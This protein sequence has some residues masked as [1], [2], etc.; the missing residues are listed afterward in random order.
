MFCISLVSCLVDWSR[1][2]SSWVCT[3]S[4]FKSLG[5]SK[6]SFGSSKFEWAS[7][8]IRSWPLLLSLTVV[9]GLF[10]FW[11]SFHVPFVRAT[12]FLNLRSCAKGPSFFIKCVIWSNSAPFGDP[13]L[14][15]GEIETWFRFIRSLAW[16]S[17]WAI[18]LN[19]YRMLYSLISVRM[20]PYLIKI[21]LV[22]PW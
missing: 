10:K 7:F 17:L 4:R 11:F 6:L 15:S 22:T 1:E 5:D 8:S 19:S 2:S 14:C 13:S 18:L 9:V 20:M 3:L 12:L 16:L 21:A